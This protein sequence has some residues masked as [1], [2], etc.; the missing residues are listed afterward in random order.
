[1]LQKNEG[2]PWVASYAGRVLSARLPDATKKTLASL[3]T[4]RFNHFIIQ[5][6][7]SKIAFLNR[8]F[9]PLTQ[10]AKAAKILPEPVAGL[11]KRPPMF[12]AKVPILEICSKRC[13]GKV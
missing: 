3:A 6:S 8:P 10:D 1:M 12:Q 13:P 7:K 4:L 9:A 11:K 2:T 5:H